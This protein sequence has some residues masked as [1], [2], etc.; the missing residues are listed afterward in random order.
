LRDFKDEIVWIR[1]KMQLAA[2]KN[3]GQSLVEVKML[4]CKNETLQ[5]EENNHEQIIN[6]VC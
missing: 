3:M 2:S 1:E 6:Q 5:K 4:Q